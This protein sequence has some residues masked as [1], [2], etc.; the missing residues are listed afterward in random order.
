MREFPF[1]MGLDYERKFVALRPGRAGSLAGRVTRRAIARGHARPPFKVR[2]RDDDERGVRGRLL[3]F[4]PFTVALLAMVLLGRTVARAQDVTEP[5]L[6]A[7]FIYNFARFTTWPADAPPGDSFVICVLNDAAV[8]EALQ[9]AVAGRSLTERPV[10]VTAVG[11]R[12]AEARLPRALRG[13]IARRR[14]SPTSSPNCAR[15]RC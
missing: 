12:R 1:G 7:A 10:V 8:A 15:H 11:A 2:P 14:R 6:K 3:R 13:G 5:A 9:R 4:I